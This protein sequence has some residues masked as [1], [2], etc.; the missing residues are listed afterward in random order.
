MSNTVKTISNRQKK[1][2]DLKQENA[3]W[4]AKVVANYGD[5]GLTNSYYFD[6]LSRFLIVMIEPCERMP[7][8]EHWPQ[9]FYL[10]QRPRELWIDVDGGVQSDIANQRRIDML[11]NVNRGAP[12]AFSWQNIPAINRPYRIGETIKV[13]K[14]RQPIFFY[15]SFFTSA[16]TSSY[17]TDVAKNS[18]NTSYLSPDAPGA[19]A[20]SPNA[21]AYAFVKTLPLYPH[22][23]VRGF[24]M[25][26][27]FY[28]SADLTSSLQ[29]TPTYGTLNNK[30]SPVVASKPSFTNATQYA[31][32]LN[33]Y[34]F[35]VF[36]RQ[37]FAVAKTDPVILNTA[38]N[39]ENA[40]KPY[41]WG[42]SS[43]GGQPNHSCIFNCCIL[44]DINEDN[45]TR[46]PTNDCMPLVVTNPATYPTPKTRQAG[47][48]KFDPTYTTITTT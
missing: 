25:G 45:K 19:A 9:M 15:D 32:G 13:R 23:G 36:W 14:T 12:S 26:G 22:D 2:Q 43:A 17:M 44:E 29:W 40:L 8:Y 7:I 41:L 16:F 11:G 4:T 1:S 46:E 33:K 35:E 6:I 24:I 37:A 38:P 20:V 47:T 21:T 3:T 10:V 30:N 48:I 39:M 31:I 27:N 18:Y 5:V 42:L 28:N 34:T